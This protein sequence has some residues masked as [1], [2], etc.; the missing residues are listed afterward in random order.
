MFNKLQQLNK[1]RKMR[2]TALNMQK[3]LKQVIESLERNNYKVKVTGDQRID[4]LEID[5]VAQPDLVRLIN[6][7]LEK[8]QKTAAKQIIQEEGISGLLKGF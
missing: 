8:V 5:G 7:A 3:K 1:L 2:S 6:E 4:Y